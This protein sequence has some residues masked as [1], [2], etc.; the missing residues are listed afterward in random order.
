[1]PLDA[2]AESDRVVVLPPLF[3]DHLGF[4]QALE[5]L[6]VEQLVPEAHVEALDVAVLPG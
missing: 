1:M 5:D 2:V 3:D 4:L 6:A